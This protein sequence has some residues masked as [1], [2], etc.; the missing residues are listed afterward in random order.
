MAPGATREDSMLQMKA[1]QDAVEEVGAQYKEKTRTIS[2]QLCD[3]GNWWK[4]QVDLLLDLTQKI[5]TN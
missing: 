5:G 2:Y 1:F 3:G 4:T